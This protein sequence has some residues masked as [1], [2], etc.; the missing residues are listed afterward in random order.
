MPRKNVKIE[1][2]RLTA[3]YQNWKNCGQNNYMNILMQNMLKPIGPVN[4]KLLR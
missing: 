4:L 1:I 2:V 3:I